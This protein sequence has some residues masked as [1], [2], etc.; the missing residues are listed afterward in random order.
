MLIKPCYW[1]LKINLSM[2]MIGH[3]FDL[4]RDMFS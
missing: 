1:L 2:S 4:V 3:L